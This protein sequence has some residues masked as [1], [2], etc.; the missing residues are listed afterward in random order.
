MT[1][2]VAKC[3]ATLL[4]VIV[5]IAT[6][7]C[8]EPRPR[9]RNVILISIDTLN[10]SVVN[11]LADAEAHLP[12]LGALVARS[13]VFTR[14]HSSASWTLPAHASL[15]TGL[16]PDRHGATARRRRLSRGV[17]TL[18]EVLKHAGFETIGFSDG[19]YV[20]H[21][22]GFSDGFHRY[23]DFVAEDAPHDGRTIIRNG[24]RDDSDSLKLFDRAIDLL[25]QREADDAPL[26]LFLQ[27]YLVHD[28][29]RV[30]PWG[31]ERA[32]DALEDS[33]YYLACLSGQSKCSNRDWQA[34]RELYEAEI[35]VLDVGLGRLMEVLRRRELLADSLVVFLSDHGEGFDP[36]RRR[37][38]HGGRLHADLIHI[39][40]LFS[41][42]GITPGRRDLPVSIVDVMPTIVDILGL[43]APARI[44][45][46]SLAP[47]LRGRRRMKERPVHASEYF[48]QWPRGVR[49]AAREPRS[50]PFSVA[51]VWGNLWYVSGQNGETVYD[52]RTDPEQRHNLAPQHRFSKRLR[53]RADKRARRYSPPLEIVDE[54]DEL[55]QHLEALGYVETI[56]P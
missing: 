5:I 33:D 30:H 25:E 17:E 45:G 7:G 27:T 49:M 44:D 1:N 28:Y 12:N 18:A 11:E 26:L 24:R 13:L 55:R 21:D 36:A 46:R 3:G 48:Y 52:M 4:C 22:Y 8:R 39:P 29:F 41:G 20:D 23:D 32:K 31:Q 9:P 6:A 54:G 42:P 2:S 15:M 40:L 56:E 10:A 53:R 47:M 50:E 37:L 16:Y 14:A 43:K 51:V 19:A 34:L 35:E 38:H